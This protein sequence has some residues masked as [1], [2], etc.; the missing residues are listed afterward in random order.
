MRILIIEDEEKIANSLKKGFINENF[1]VEV[2]ADGEKGLSLARIGN[3]DLI[4]LDIMLPKIDG[5]TVLKQLREDKIFT[6][7]ILLTAKDAINDKVK[8]LNIGADDYLT[9]PFSFEELLARVHSLI[10]RSTSKETLLR[11][12]NLEL[13]PLKHTVKRSDKLIDISAKEFAILE[14][15]LRH[16]DAVVSESQLIDHAW[17]NDYDGFSNVVA[18]HIKNIRLK[19]DKSFPKDKQLLKNIRGLGYKIS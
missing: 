11:V 2:A 1:L 6:P 10:R 4:I 19:I 14:Y 18:A 5:V 7:V 9:K 16:K 15:L 8:G 17:D 3:V 13:D 12:D